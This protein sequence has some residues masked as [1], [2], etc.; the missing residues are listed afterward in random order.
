MSDT[1]DISVKLV[2]YA[3][4][5]VVLEVDGYEYHLEPEQA[6]TLTEAFYDAAQDAKEISEWRE[7]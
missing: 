4:G 6:E 7:A 1:F 2:P 5:M 3:P